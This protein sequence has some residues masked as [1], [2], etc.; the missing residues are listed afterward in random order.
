MNVKKGLNG[1]LA[2]LVALVMVSCGQSS[3]NSKE[4]AV[5][6][7]ST[8]MIPAFTIATI[9]D[10]T[11]YNYQSISTDGIVLIKYFSPD[12]SHCQE[13][14]KVFLSKKD[15]LENIRTLWTSGDW[16]DLGKISRFATEYQLDQLNPIAIGKETANELLVHY[17]FRSVPFTAVFKDNQLIKTYEGDIDF[18]ELIA[19]NNGTWEPA[20]VV[21]AGEAS[22]TEEN[23]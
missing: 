12:C 19:I 6:Q 10:S 2:A 13:E 14:A 15:S 4:Q 20:P 11:L 8:L 1:V 22:D 23:D 3:S 18:D 21:K 5:V 7:D 9:N 16:A 17:G